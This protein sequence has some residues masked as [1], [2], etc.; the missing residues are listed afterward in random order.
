M[1]NLFFAWVNFRIDIARAR[2]PTVRPRKG[3]GGVWRKNSGILWKFPK[4]FLTPLRKCNF[5]NCEKILLV[6][7]E[8][9]WLEDIKMA[10]INNGKKSAR[11]SEYFWYL[12]NYIMEF[13]DFQVVNQALGLN[14]TMYLKVKQ[15]FG[16]VKVISN[17]WNNC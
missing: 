16:Y 5:V 10:V 15:Y 2:R 1:K 3:N 4:S 11:C 7:T 13:F 6:N 14:F 9:T 8:L 17:Y 12:Q